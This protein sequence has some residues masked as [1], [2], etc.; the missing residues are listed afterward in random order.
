MK[1]VAASATFTLE[2]IDGIAKYCKNKK[3][4]KGQGGCW[5][6]VCIGYKCGLYTYSPLNPLNQ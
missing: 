3:K 2:E 5:H 4:E 6:K 1:P